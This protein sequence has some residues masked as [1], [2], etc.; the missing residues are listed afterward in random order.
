MVDCLLLNNSGQSAFLLKYGGENEGEKKG[1]GTD[2]S[3]AEK[4]VGDQL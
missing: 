4:A 1:S 3:H 2:S